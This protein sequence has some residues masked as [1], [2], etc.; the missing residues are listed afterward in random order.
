VGRVDWAWRSDV[1]K[2]RRLKVSSVG[3]IRFMGGPF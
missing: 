3:R 2:L 1:E